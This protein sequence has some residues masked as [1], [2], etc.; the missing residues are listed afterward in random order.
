MTCGLVTLLS[1]MVTDLITPVSYFS[2]IQEFARTGPD[3]NQNID[4][5]A[6]ATVD[7]NSLMAI[8]KVLR[9]K[10]IACEKVL[11]S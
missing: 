8:E 7:V 10:F 9:Q 1:S 4:E 3:A 5:S 6:G 11:F 2:G